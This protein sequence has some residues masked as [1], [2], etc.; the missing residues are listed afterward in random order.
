MNL[1]VLFLTMWINSCLFHNLQ[2]R[3]SHQAMESAFNQ[4]ARMPRGLLRFVWFRTSI[5]EADRMLNR[6]ELPYEKIEDP[7][8]LSGGYESAVKF[9]F[10][11]S[12]PRLLQ[13]MWSA[14]EVWN[15]EILVN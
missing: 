10:S 9:K 1:G 3:T 13:N 5:A 7:R 14:N 15:R 8:R 12:I 2:T 6:E 11:T 4:F